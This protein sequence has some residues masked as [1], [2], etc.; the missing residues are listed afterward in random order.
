[1]ASQWRKADP[2][3][4]ADTRKGLNARQYAFVE[5]QADVRLRVALRG[6]IHAG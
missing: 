4:G 5:V 3:S 6:K 2:P 1:M